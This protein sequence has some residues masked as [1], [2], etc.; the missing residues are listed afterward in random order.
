MELMKEMPYILAQASRTDEILMGIYS[1]YYQKMK[2]KSILLGCI[3]AQLMIPSDAL[4]SPWRSGPTETKT[5]RSLV[6]KEE[7]GYESC[8]S[9]N[10]ALKLKTNCATR[11]DQQVKFTEL[12]R[13]LQQ[14]FIYA[15]KY[16]QNLNSSEGGDTIINGMRNDLLSG[17]VSAG[18]KYVNQ[19]VK[20]IPFLSQAEL[21]IDLN[22]E[23]DFTYRINSLVKIKG[24]GEDA[25]GK[26]MGLIF[27]QGNVIATASS[28]A[29]TNLGLG[30]RKRIN[31]NAMVGVNAFWDYR[32]TSYSS[33]Y[34]RWGAGAEL[35]WDDFK[36]IN[37]WYIAGTGTKNVEIDG[38]AFKERV[39]PGWDLAMKYRLPDYPQL[40]F[41]IRGFRWD[42]LK[43]DD[44]IGVE[45]SIDW[46][47]TPRTSLAAWVSNENPAYPTSSN[48]ALDKRNSDTYFGVKFALKL[49]PLNYS[50]GK[51][52]IGNLIT[53]MTQPVSRKYE[54]LLERYSEQSSAF[55]VRAIGL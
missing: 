35:W 31:D 1:E 50:K 49:R 45:G 53:E 16:F 34:S 39:V 14:G 54:V 38:S 36:L 9:V 27:A 29:T 25:D 30:A 11:S 21:Q 52:K 6:S 55:Q 10:T 51:D 44:N 41:G 42:Y 3:F 19:E 22:S 20:K 33:A 23:A 18:N 17:I 2:I 40:A 15:S 37:N 28:N 24:L 26:S 47:I 48:S 4:A 43:R 12:E 8:E 5:R 46:N 13:N 32:M 7:F